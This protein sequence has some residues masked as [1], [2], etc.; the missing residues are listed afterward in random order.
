MVVFVCLFVLQDCKEHLAVQAS[1]GISTHPGRVT[2]L[3]TFSGESRFAQG[4]AL[5][6]G[7]TILGT[8]V[9]SAKWCFLPVCKINSRAEY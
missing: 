6:I 2:A 9:T 7:N 1:G 3:S 4:D 8:H 5:T